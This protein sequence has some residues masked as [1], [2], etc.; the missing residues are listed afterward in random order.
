MLRLTW[1]MEVLLMMNT[2]SIATVGTSAMRI[3]RNAFA[4][5]GSTPIMSNSMKS[6]LISLI[7]ILN[8]CMKS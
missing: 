2:C 8:C 4:I 6:S 3:R 7:S 5:A 1:M